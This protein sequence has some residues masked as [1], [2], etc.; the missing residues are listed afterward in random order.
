MPDTW[1][2]ANK[3]NPLDYI[4]RNDHDLDEDYTNIEYYLNTLID[5]FY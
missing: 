4:D 3:L 1:E 5:N 2:T